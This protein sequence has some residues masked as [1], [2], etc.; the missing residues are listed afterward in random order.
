MTEECPYEEC[1]A[2]FT[3]EQA[4]IA[5][6]EHVSAVHIHGTVASEPAEP[7]TR[8]DPELWW[9]PTKGVLRKLAGDQA[10]ALG[11]GDC[12]GWF[13]S[14]WWPDDA[15]QLVLVDPA[16]TTELEDRAEL[17]D[18]L[19][20]ANE[21]IEEQDTRISQLEAEV[22]KQR[23]IAKNATDH[24]QQG[25]QRMRIQRDYA[26]ARLELRKLND[27]M[28][29]KN[30]VIAKR[31]AERDALSLLL[32]GMARKLVA[33]RKW[34]DGDVPTVHRL[35][36]ELAEA[37]DGGRKVLAIAEQFQAERDERQARIDAALVV[38]DGG[39][40]FALMPGALHAIRAALVGDQPNAPA[41]ADRATEVADAL[42][43]DPEVFR[44]DIEGTPGGG[45][46]GAA[47]RAAEEADDASE[48]ACECFVVPEEQWTRHYDAT[49]PGSM[50][51]QNPDCP[52][53]PAGQPDDAAGDLP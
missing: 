41:V 48:P 17:A 22:V 18:Q 33:Y 31:R 34:A 7:T 50:V 21:H 25:W 38:L 19:A 27:A 51:E 44:E 49:E 16:Q 28:I 12:V 15:V 53:H 1:D 5:V 29:R 26:S 11:G 14:T 39:V 52:V 47:L 2:T 42:A 10:Q 37:R 32:R 46:S 43:A 23:I 35:R 40:E 13:P 30:R 36:R 20:S 24:W 45:L 9:S 3:G 6:V 8:Q 4:D